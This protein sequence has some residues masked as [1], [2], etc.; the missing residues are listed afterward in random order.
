MRIQFISG[1]VE[2]VPTAKGSYN[3]LMVTF[4]NLD[5]GKVEV[6]QVM[7]FA[8]PEVYK[9]LTSATTNELFVIDL[10]K[11]PGKD[12]KEYWTWT[13]IHRDDGVAPTPV[14]TPVAAKGVNT[15]AEKNALDRERFE[16]DKEK[17]ALIIRQSCLSSAV[18]LMKD[19][20]KQPDVQKVLDVA[21]QFELWVWARGVAD[22]TEDVPV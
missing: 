15:Y 14:E 22:L 21:K 2:N 19:H 6:K 9:R 13:G 12:G 10:E 7:D 17:Q 16:F 20:G 3:K 18:D 8:S 4:K 1:N 5:S 11:K